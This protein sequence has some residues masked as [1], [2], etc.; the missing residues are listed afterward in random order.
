MARV[1]FTVNHLFTATP[2]VVWDE[3]VDWEGHGAW[4]P[5]TRVDV[6][7]GD[8]LAIGATFVAWTGYGPLTLEDRMEVAAI[9]WSSEQQRGECTVNKLGPVLGGTASFSVE[10]GP[11]GGAALTWIEDVHVPRVPQFLARITGVMGAGGFKLAMLSLA[12]QIRKTA[13]AERFARDRNN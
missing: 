11:D 7:P 6:A 1:A 4:I 5:A 2:Q 8:P 10:P 9:E 3:L 13:P 12:R